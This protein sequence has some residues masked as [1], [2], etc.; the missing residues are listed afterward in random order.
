MKELLITFHKTLSLR[1]LNVFLRE[2]K[3]PLER[4]QPQFIRD[5]LIEI[6]KN[7]KINSR[8]KP[9]IDIHENF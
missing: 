7:F 5:N 1:S 2:P 9:V 6:H 8:G 4:S 3:S